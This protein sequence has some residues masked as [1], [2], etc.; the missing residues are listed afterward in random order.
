MKALG[1]LRISI[2]ITES[3]CFACCGQHIFH[4]VQDYTFLVGCYNFHCLC[5]SRDVGTG[6]IFFILTVTFVILF[7]KI[8]GVFWLVYLDFLNFRTCFGKQSHQLTQSRGFVEQIHINLPQLSD[9]VKRSVDSNHLNYFYINQEIKC[10]W[11][12]DFSRHI[13]HLIWLKS[14]FWG[15]YITANIAVSLMNKKTNNDKK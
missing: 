15:R 11:S 8:S 14:T 12:P 2:C 7:F 6:N 3:S 10:I 1:K 4:W 13:C 9:L 5:E